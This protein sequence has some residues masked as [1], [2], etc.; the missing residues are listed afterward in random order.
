MFSQSKFNEIIEYLFQK[1]DEY[2]KVDLIPV[3]TKKIVENQDLHVY[4]MQKI[5]GKYDPI[6]ESKDFYEL[7][8]GSK[9]FLHLNNYQFYEDQLKFAYGNKL[10]DTI[11]LFFL[12][13]FLKIYLYKK[14]SMLI[15]EFMIL[16]GSFYLFSLGLRESKDV[17]IVFIN[18]KYYKELFKEMS[19]QYDIL[20][21]SII[22]KMVLN[23]NKYAIYFGFKGNMIDYEISKRM[24]RLNKTESKRALADIIILKYYFNI[25]EKINANSD[26]EKLLFFR[27]KNF[28]KKL[29]H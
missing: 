3:H 26:I 16:S 29:Y 8:E 12:L 17:D 22:E 6:Y 19:C 1:S 28:T 25:G 27:Y 23:P 20:F 7:V 4:V 15:Q 21:S 5:E 13:K 11:R 2:K 10:K 24:H 9:I 18:K 14:H